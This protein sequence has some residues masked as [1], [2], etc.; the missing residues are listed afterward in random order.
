MLLMSVID[1]EEEGMGLA[2]HDTAANIH[3][4]VFDECDRGRG[5]S[6]GCSDTGCCCQWGGQM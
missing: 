1:G 2:I 5:G 3:H 4:N 6:G